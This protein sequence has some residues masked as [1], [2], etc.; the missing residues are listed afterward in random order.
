V[1]TNNNAPPAEPAPGKI[2]P[3]IKRWA[4]ALLGVAAG[5]QIQSQGAGADA[6]D[7]VKNFGAPLAILLLSGAKLTQWVEK[8][9]AWL[10]PRLETVSEAFQAIADA[11]REQMRI[12]SATA[13][14]LEEADELGRQER[15]DL[16]DSMAEVKRELASIA[17]DIKT[18]KKRF[19]HLYQKLTGDAVEV[20]IPQDAGS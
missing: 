3:V 19:D 5:A 1:D 2:I 15:G 10:A 13:A 8:A 17:R 7:L 11:S 16:A 4:P 14:R 6:V 18:L 20:T 12:A 9:V